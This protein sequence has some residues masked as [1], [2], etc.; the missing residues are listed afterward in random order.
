MRPGLEIAIQFPAMLL[1]I[2]SFLPFLDHFIGSPARKCT[3]LALFS[4]YCA[5]SILS[6]AVTSSSAGYTPAKTSSAIVLVVVLCA[7]SKVEALVQHHSQHY[8]SH[9]SPYG[10]AVHP[11]RAGPLQF[12][13]DCKDLAGKNS[14]WS[15]PP[16]SCIKF[17][18]ARDRFLISDQ[19][20]ISTTTEMS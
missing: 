5:M 14:S 20:C 4:L 7:L 15:R 17:S 6:A 1:Y 3:Y 19:D 13:F 2:P 18:A 8:G 16:Q 9:D 12:V 11:H 10:V